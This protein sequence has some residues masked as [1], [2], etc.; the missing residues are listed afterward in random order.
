MLRWEHKHKLTPAKTAGADERNVAT[1]SV[2]LWSRSRWTHPLSCLP[3]TL[4]H[5]AHVSQASADPLAA[6]HSIWKLIASSTISTSAS[7]IVL[8]RLSRRTHHVSSSSIVAS[9][10]APDGGS[11]YQVRHPIEGAHPTSIFS[12]SDTPIC[13]H[14]KTR[15]ICRRYALRGRKGLDVCTDLEIPVSP[16]GFWLSLFFPVPPFLFFFLEK[17]RPFCS[18]RLETSA[19]A[20]SPRTSNGTL[21]V[22]TR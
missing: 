6:K 2:S 1:P 17:I 4:V 14:V 13:A 10:S 21:R 16:F 7:S 19:K 3:S 22:S 12:Q 15:P 5:A 9:A 11:A 8:S 20:S 18:G